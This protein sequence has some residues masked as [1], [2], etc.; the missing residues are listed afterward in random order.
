MP[1][2]LVQTSAEF[3]LTL[4]LRCVPPAPRKA[5]EP[6]GPTSRVFSAIINGTAQS[7]KERL[8]AT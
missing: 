3:P 2:P 5:P 4:D 7:E 6:E 1:A 8:T